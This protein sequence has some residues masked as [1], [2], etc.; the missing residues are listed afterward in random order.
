MSS[1]NNLTIGVT[2]A[3]INCPRIRIVGDA[4]SLHGDGVGHQRSHSRCKLVCS[5]QSTP[6]SPMSNRSH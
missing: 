4:V 3:L 2:A 5:H 6:F 1:I